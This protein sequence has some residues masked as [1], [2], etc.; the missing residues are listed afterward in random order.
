[1]W[2]LGIETAGERGGVAVLGDGG[3]GYELTF[4]AGRVH[5]EVV[6]AATDAVTRTAGI[7]RG[8]ISL[9][10]VDV[11]PGSFTG[12]RIGMAFACGLAQSLDLPTVGVRQ[13][14]VV[15]LSAVKYWPGRVVVWIHD[16][17]DH[18]YSAWVSDDRVGQDT[19]LPL[20]RALE[21]VRGRDQLLV[22]G[23]GAW[24]FRERIAPLAP[25]VLVG[26]GCVHAE[27]LEVARRGLE[28]SQM[29]RAVSP[30]EL[31]PHYV[32]PPAAR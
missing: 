5:A 12:I 13:S 32:H 6:G 16:R 8:D 24:R 9:L 19:A 21:R 29:G 7:E 2:V 28:L 14:E 31:E 11:G 15:G 23:S 27:P 1:M 25:D 4:E 10:A 17:G 26:L 18:V 22:V 30:G 3:Q 20:Q